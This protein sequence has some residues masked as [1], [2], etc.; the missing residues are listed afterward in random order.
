MTRS[1]DTSSS[2]PYVLPIRAF[3]YLI[4]RDHHEQDFQNLCT[5]ISWTSLKA[6]RF[7]IGSRFTLSYSSRYPDWTPSYLNDRICIRLSYDCI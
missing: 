1:T 7:Y 6:E 5:Q 3:A 2:I 4:L